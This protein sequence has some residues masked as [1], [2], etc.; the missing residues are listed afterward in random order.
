MSW[1]VT[2]DC[3]LRKSPKA[4]KGQIDLYE[5]DTLKLWDMMKNG[6]MNKKGFDAWFNIHGSIHKPIRDD[7]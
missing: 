2:D 5:V 7:K 1:Y 6:Q 4:E 3:Y